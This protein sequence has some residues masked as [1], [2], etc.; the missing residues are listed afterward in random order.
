V[1]RAFAVR[2]SPAG[3]L[4]TITPARASGALHVGID[5][6]TWIEASPRGARDVERRDTSGVAVY[7]GAFN[8]GDLVYVVESGRAEELRVARTVA[9]ARQLT[10]DLRLGPALASVRVRDGRVEALDESGAVRLSTEPAYAV[11]AV[12]VRRP[13]SFALKGATLDATLD[14]TGLATP[15]TID[16]AWTATGSLSAVR[17]MP[18]A[19]KLASGKVLVIGGSDPVTRQG[20]STAE[21]Y[22]PATNTWTMTAGAMSA[23]RSGPAATAF[24]A[25][26]KVLVSGGDASG[27]GPSSVAEIYDAATNRFTQVVMPVTSRGH[28]S[29]LLAD[30]KVALI[31][32][33]DGSRAGISYVRTFDP[34][35]STFTSTPS[36]LY[37]GYGG[38]ITDHTATVVPGGKVVIAGGRAWPGGEVNFINDATFVYD[39]VAVTMTRKADLPAGRDSHGAVY[40]STGPKGG[41]ILLFGGSI[42][43]ID[44][45]ETASAG[46]AF[47]D[48]ATNTF[49]PGPFMARARSYFGWSVLPSG[50]IVVT[51]GAASL[52]TPTIDAEDTAEVFDPLT[53]TWSSAGKMIDKR[54]V[55]V[56]VTLTGESVLVAGGVRGAKEGFFDATTATEKLVLQANGSACEGGGQC[57][58][59][60][61]A[62]GVCCDMACTDICA[63]CDVSGK[64]GI[65]SPV[66]GAPHGT[67]TA[68]DPTAAKGD[69]CALAC[70]GTDTAACHFPSAT[71]AC[72][73]DACSGG[74]ET[75]ASTCD[76]AGKCNDAPTTCGD[77][78]CGATACKTAC[79]TG[80]DCVNADRFCEAGKCIPFLSNAIPCTRDEACASKHCVDGVC[81][82][83]TCTG[84][85]E[86]CD[87][88]GQ[89]G[90]CVPVKG[91][92]HNS[93]AACPAD[94]KASCGSKVCDGS[95]TASCAGTLDCGNY[96]CDSVALVCKHEC[97]ADS[98]CAAGFQCKEGK[99]VPQTSKCSSDLADMVGTDGSKT[100]C[101]PYLCRD[102]VCLADCK[103][104]T[105]CRGGFI[106]DPNQHCVAP[107][108]AADSGDSGGCSTSTRSSSA[109]MALLAL[110]A[111]AALAVR[112]RAA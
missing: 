85:C 52:S 105:D 102:G 112:R 55:G 51:G 44:G 6:R 107:T 92:P 22:D 103:S 94:D 80:A 3:A 74:R 67:R 83:S 12:G 62:D 42:R 7:P 10:W 69:V 101:S 27:F 106:C 93:R 37:G 11:D 108:A 78:V 46:S 17:V 31:G 20:F 63:A 90:K 76:G 4:K 40:L 77:Y 99:C 75:H 65:C 111:L 73:A 21:L 68:C 33:L 82:E 57:T 50:K 89:A 104:S 96:G 24:A 25:G 36:I 9:A 43:G 28:S 29:T 30:G 49:S 19:A 15:I 59:G 56:Q 2:P 87:V 13:L 26:T 23:P 60:F 84:Q 86:A 39:P 14:V 100:S 38:G 58:S 72:S 71:T 45:S 88:P 5:E 41:K 18:V 97:A 54:C 109:N 16:P 66:A 98:D 1:R 110:A 81:C 61:C 35:T 53:L 70:N 95:N 34:N 64:V 91:K 32:G 8:G 79:T 47:Y 48:V